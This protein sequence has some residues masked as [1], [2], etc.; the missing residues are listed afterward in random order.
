MLVLALLIALLV[1]VLTA[2]I[3]ATPFG[4]RPTASTRCTF[5]W[6]R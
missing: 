5:A 2:R 4:R 3:C 6:I 1:V